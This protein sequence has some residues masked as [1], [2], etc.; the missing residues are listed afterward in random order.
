MEQDE[1]AYSCH[2]RLFGAE[3]AVF[4]PHAS[5]HLI[6]QARLLFPLRDIDK[7]LRRKLRRY[8]WKQWVTISPP[9][10]TGTHVLF[11]GHAE[12]S[13]PVLP[14]TTR[15]CVS[16]GARTAPVTVLVEAAVRPRCSQT[17]IGHRGVRPGARRAS[18][19]V[20]GLKPTPWWLG[21]RAVLRAT[22][23]PTVAAFQSDWLE[24]T[25]R[26]GLRPSA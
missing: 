9:G 22:R 3:A 5:P 13:M 20:S 14:L 24:A 6:A 21:P 1:P 10:S 23:V 4:Q 2:L 11:P 8:I 15:C 12:E 7:W 16:C 25:P 26:S 19:R 18:H 17:L